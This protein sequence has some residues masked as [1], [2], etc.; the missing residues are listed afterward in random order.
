MTPPDGTGA[1]LD[2]ATWSLTGSADVNEGANA[3]YTVHLDGTLQ[4]GETA[5]VH[6]ALANVSTT[7]ADY[8]SFTAAITAAI[9]ARTDVV[10]DFGTGTLTYTGTGSPMTDLTI[11]LGAVNDSLVEGN[12]QYTVSLSSPGSTTGA[13]VVGTGSVTTTIHDP[14][15]ALVRARH[16]DLVAH[17][18]RRRQRR[19]QCELHGAPRWHAA[20]GRTATVRLALANVSTTSA[21]YASFTAAITAAIGARTDVVFNSGTGTLTY[22]GTGSP[23]TD[24][25]ISLGA[26]NDGLV[27]GNEQYT[28]SLRAPAAPPVPMWS[29]PAR[30]PPPSMT[31][32]MALV[33]RSTPRPGR[34][35]APPTSTKAPMRATRCTSMARCRRARRRPCIWRWPMSAPPA[36]T[37]RASQLQSRRRSARV[38]MWSSTPAPAR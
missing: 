12:E 2:T 23:M 11:S 28:V 29:A 15:M 21:D 17:G 3:S 13:N 33:P 27:E 4:A 26:V 30:S 32:P 24:L 14:P 20:G 8:A 10:F 1:A 25:T 34:S 16:R 19:R 22:T 7:S 38:P 9:G 31:P 37:M 6:L 5:T 36:P 18:L 35:R